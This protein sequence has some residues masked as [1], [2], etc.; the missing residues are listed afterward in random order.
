MVQFCPYLVTCLSTVKN[1]QLLLAICSLNLA[2]QLFLAVN[3]RNV[4]T[5]AYSILK[6]TIHAE[7]YVSGMEYV[8]FAEILFSFFS[9][10]LFNCSCCTKWM[11]C[12]STPNSDYCYWRSSRY[13]LGVNE[14]CQLLYLNALCIRDFEL[15]FKVC[16]I[17]CWEMNLFIVTTQF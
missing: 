10:I 17:F 1:L 7:Y 6:I 14:V 12:S 9:S 2:L 5:F 13:W 16:S 8:A 15:D 11:G 4:R 3:K